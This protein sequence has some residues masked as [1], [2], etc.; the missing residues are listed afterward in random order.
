[1]HAPL[2]EPLHELAGAWRAATGPSRRRFALAGFVL[3]AL[4][5]MLVARQGTG[6]ARLGAA[7][8]IAGGLVAAVG[9]RAA[10]R[11]RLRDPAAIVRGRVRRVDP[12]RADRALR[13]LS[14]LGGAADAR[15]DGTSEELARL[16]VSRVLSAV[17]VAR[18]VE[19]AARSGAL[20]G[21]VAIVA[22]ACAL[23]VLWLRGWA[24]LEGADVFAAR[25]GVAPVA[26][27]WLDEVDVSARPPDYLQDPE[28]TDLAM[29]SL[30]LPYGT[31]VTVRGAPT[32]AGR[33]LLL[34]DG[35]TEVPF[36]ED[37][38]G[39][40]VAR[41]VLGPSTTLRIDARFG[42]V[43]VA[44][45][46]PFVIESIPDAAPEVHLEGAPRQVVVADQEQQDIALAYEASDDHGLREVELV[47]RSGTREERRV[48][49]R[50]DGGTKSDRGGYVLRFR[51]A[52]VRAS[53]APIE[54]TVEA[55]DNDPLTGPKWGAS[56]AIILVPPSVGEPEARRLDAIRRLRDALVDGLAW[57]LA[58]PPPDEANLRGGFVAES[59]KHAAEIDAL[60]TQTTTQ[61]YAG[62]RVPSRIR[63]MI[64]A[65]AEAARKAI[66]G[67]TRAPSAASHAQAVAAVERFVLVVD[68]VIRGLGMHDAR[69]SAH[70]LA[71][72]ADEL[73]SGAAQA[74]GGATEKASSAAAG[75][76][77]ASAS[78]DTLRMDAATTG[79]VGGGQ[80]LLRLGALGR[81]LGE[82]VD[83]DL[84]R[85]RRGR[86]ENDLGHAELAARDLAARLRQADPSFG[87]RGGRPGR[88]G[89]ESGSAPGAAGDDATPPDEVERAFEESAR[90]LEQLAQDHAGEMS[91]IERLVRDATS[92]E[93]AEEL[94]DEAKR[95]A[96][97]IREAA[98]GLPSVGTGSDS[99]TSKG[100][101]ARELA[102]QM[103]RA[104]EGSQAGD[105]V[106]SGRSAVG[107]LDEAKKI[108]ER[109]GWF[110]DPS[111]RDLQ[112]IDDA[113]RKLATEERW[114]EQAVEQLRKRA[115]DRARKAL[116]EGGEEEGKLADRARDVAR[117]GKDR[118]SLPE[119]ALESVEDAERAARQAS[120]ALREGNADRGIERQREAQ[121]ALEAAS[122]HLHDDDE[123]QGH[124][125]QGGEASESDPGGGGPLGPG[126]Y[127]APDKFRRRV[128][129]G[130]E[131]PSSGALR[132]AVRRYA[133]GLLR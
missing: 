19:R 63:A 29:T 119:D 6:R 114:A 13:A 115:S 74:K 60:V 26:M 59:G 51:D 43:V 10:D 48:L 124:P 76:K 113:R 99:W 14:L 86:D 42:D 81:D 44:Q 66:D 37:G 56:Q 12:E 96:E 120:D 22:F 30:M 1:M 123:S 25:G 91:K 112:R 32:H 87:S 85:V 36:V 89:G 28:R 95:H 17:P 118:G 117:Q 50:L 72:V 18:V 46:D 103:A 131:Q 70:G 116:Q 24:V 52:F 16:H 38:A 3:V 67:E 121:R 20:L 93:E 125:G 69:A 39:A 27:R 133:E 73:S 129:R 78:R 84:L 64:V 104:L 90:D 127:K 58:T 126:D 2:T 71:D 88:A 54:V 108:L 68:A 80:A 105:A 79:L 65:Q 101:A 31:A 107:S 106:Q 8:L 62:V 11:R 128:L 7:L 23:G 130:L 75:T 111:G 83:A 53:H 110:E 34:S 57:R 35:V 102:E 4:V 45:A 94:R 9:W 92:Q 97:A 21:R 55:E 77:N 41:W 49:A 122:A 98:R 47:L 100:A 61:T 82:I 33:R 109:G 15:R 40:A 5:A 132:D